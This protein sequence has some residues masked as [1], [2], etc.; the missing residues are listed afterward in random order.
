MEFV[1]INRSLDKEVE[2]RKLIKNVRLIH[3]E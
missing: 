1:H 3:G 2:Y